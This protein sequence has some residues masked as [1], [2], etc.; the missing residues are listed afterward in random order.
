[1]RLCRSPAWCLFRAGDGTGRA[2]RANWSRCLRPGNS[3]LYT[4]WDIG[5]R[6]DTAIWWY[7]V[8][9]REIH[10]IDYHASSGQTIGFYTKLVKDKPYK[11]GTHWLPH[12]ARAKTLASGGKSIIEQLSRTGLTSRR[13]PSCRTLRCRTASRLRARQSANLLVR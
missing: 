3:G 2:R 12:D 6:D 13:S 4:A 11:Y 8:V 10:V 1:V 5:Y 7:Q 9:R